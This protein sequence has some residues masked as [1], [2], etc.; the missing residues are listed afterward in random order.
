MARRYEDAISQYQR[1]VQMDANILNA[2]RGM[3]AAYTYLGLYDRALAV[4]K[5]ATG[6][7]PLGTEDQELKA[8]VG[9]VLAVSGRRIEAQQILR[10]LTARY[11][12]TGEELAGSIAA[13]HAGL[14]ANDRAIEWLLRARER[15]DPELGYLKVDPRWDG[16]RRDSRFETLLKSLGFAP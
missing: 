14:G 7:A 6:R 13:I 9:Y 10:A 5:D 16:L 12:S 1:A 8:D 2:Y 11:E 4:A 3:T 15:R